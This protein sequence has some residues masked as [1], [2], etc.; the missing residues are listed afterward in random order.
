MAGSQRSDDGS[1][2]GA[3]GARFVALPLGPAGVHR[4][5]VHSAGVHRA[6]VHSVG[7]LAPA[8]DVVLARV[9]ELPAT[10][11]LVVARHA[12]SYEL[13]RLGRVDDDAVELWPLD[14]GQPARQLARAGVVGTVILRWHTDD[15]R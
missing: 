15:L 5:G 9:G 7:T 11:G 6:G 12:D 4:A 3:G 8:D 1:G 2:S 13:G 10:G 14:P